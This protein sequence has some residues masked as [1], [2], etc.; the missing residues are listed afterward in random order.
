M[1]IKVKNKQSID[2]DDHDGF[3]EWL[4]DFLISLA[5]TAALVAIISSLIMILYI[6][7]LGV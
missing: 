2:Y 5:M 6:L 3:L 4:F 7:F 1:I